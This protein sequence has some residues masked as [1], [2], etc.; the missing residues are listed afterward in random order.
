VAKGCA[1]QAAML[2]PRYRVREFNVLDK[3]FHEVY[4]EWAT[5]SETGTE[6]IKRNVLF[7]KNSILGS[8]KWLTFDRE[9][10]FDISLV[11]SHET[12]PLIARIEPPTVPDVDP[13]ATKRIKIKVVLSHYGIIAIEEAQLIIEEKIEEANKTEAKEPTTEATQTKKKIKTKRFNCEFK[14]SP[15]QGYL[16]TEM[17]NAFLQKEIEMAKEDVLQQETK[18]AFNELEAYVYDLRD[19]LSNN[20]SQFAT[21]AELR[22]SQDLLQSVT[23][24]LDENFNAS[25]EDCRQKLELLKVD[26]LKKQLSYCPTLTPFFSLK[27]IQLFIVIM[28]TMDVNLLIKSV[29]TCYK[30]YAFKW[31]LLNTAM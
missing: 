28:N 9:K 5:T 31:H 1:L 24:W 21:A 18:E 26:K 2:N 10:A 15:R 7:E 12:E 6:T 11:T 4:V 25:R 8:T 20:Y 14:I 27:V 13:E 29:K 17:K 30:I 19:K 16:T 23:V 22:E 3:C